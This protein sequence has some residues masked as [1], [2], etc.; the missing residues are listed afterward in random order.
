M[1]TGSPQRVL[2]SR[3]AQ[4]GGEKAM[5]G[6]PSDLRLDIERR[7]KIS[8]GEQDCDQDKE[9]GIG[10]APLPSKGKSSE[11]SSKRHK[12]SKYVPAISTL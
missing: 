5:K 11:K 8:V 4:D 9:K 12:K 2:L 3:F 6:D 7:K 10:D 1:Q